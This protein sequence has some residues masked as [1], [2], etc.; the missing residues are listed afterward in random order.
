MQTAVLCSPL[1]V[2]CSAQAQLGLCLAPQPIIDV[3]TNRNPPNFVICLRSFY[4]TRIWTVI[5]ARS[6]QPHSVCLFKRR[7]VRVSCKSAY[8]CI[9]VSERNVYS[10]IAPF[11]VRFLIVLRL[12]SNAL[13]IPGNH[14]KRSL[15]LSGLH[16]SFSNIMLWTT[17]YVNVIKN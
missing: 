1:W 14:H 8:F 15:H 5:N 9:F 6:K 16:E 10:P 7:M 3:T 13:F 4:Q 2:W 12:T 11:P 17:F